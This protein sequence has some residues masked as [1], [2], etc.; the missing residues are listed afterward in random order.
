[1]FGWAFGKL[2]EV[3]PTIC[4]HDDHEVFQGNLWGDGGKLLT[5]EQWNSTRDCLAGFVEPVEMVNVVMKTN[6]SHLPDPYDST[7]MEN[8]IQ[9]Y[10]T[11]LVYGGVSFAIVG[12]RVF[13]SG[14]EQVAFW[15]GRLDHLKEPLKDLS[16]LD[17]PGLTFLGDR[18]MDFLNHWIRDWQG[19]SM[20][21]LLSQ[22]VFSY[23]TSHSG[24]DS[25]YL[26]GDLDSGGWPKRGRDAALDLMRKAFAFHICGD[27]HLP[28]LLQYGIEG[29]RDA[30]WVFCTPAI[31]VGY[32]RY[33]Q[34]DLL[35]WPVL[36]RPAHGHPNTG[37][38]RSGLGNLNYV[39][40]VGNPDKLNRH[41]NRYKQADLKSSGYGIIRF[42][43]ATRDITSEAYR[44]LSKTEDG[45]YL[46][47]PGWPHTINQL[48]NYGR[49]PV[50]YL[51]PL[52]VQGMEDP[53][54]EVTNEANG[55]LE[56]ILRIK[57]NRFT[58]KVF[59]MNPY[60]IRIGDPEKDQWQTIENVKPLPSTESDE[61]ETM[62]VVF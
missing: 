42:N 21:V 49:E 43:L 25:S 56:Y 32:Q 40:A 55:E 6:S 5:L 22:T 23:A 53:V 50:A 20:K 15:E 24:N 31:A 59:S 8:D 36:D 57:G 29:Y 7:P 1:M 27:Q 41:E 11:D 16:V 39:Y 9:V 61:A 26:E 12:D 2:M 47:F 4:I 48:D 58:P 18:Q 35:G 30:G 19:A 51:P 28:L 17:K 34:P 13:K 33:F 38:Y 54:I 44:F 45:G 10:Y 60:S 62:K 14:P 46:Q 3:R 37:K 52:E